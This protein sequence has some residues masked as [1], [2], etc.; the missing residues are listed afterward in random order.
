[1]L[2]EEKAKLIL[3][4][5]QGIT[6]LEWKKIRRIIDIYFESEATIQENKIQLASPKVIVDLC[7]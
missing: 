1:M 4:T 5:M 7:K 2:N 3:E 6:Y